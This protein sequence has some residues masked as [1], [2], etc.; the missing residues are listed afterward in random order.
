MK[1]LDDMSLITG[2]SLP[3]TKATA[4]AVDDEDAKNTWRD[5]LAFAF[6]AILH[7]SLSCLH[8]VLCLLIQFVKRLLWTNTP[9]NRASNQTQ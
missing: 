7:L 3:Y 4:A 1:L 5:Y 6:V 8:Y 2:T 9:R